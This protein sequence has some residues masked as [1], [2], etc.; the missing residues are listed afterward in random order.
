MIRRLPILFFIL[1]VSMTTIQVKGQDQPKNDQ[2]Q[3]RFNYK[4]LAQDP[5]SEYYNENINQPKDNVVAR[6]NYNFSRLKNPNTGKVPRNIREKELQYVRAER[7]KLQRSDDDQLIFKNGINIEAAAGDQA[8]AWDNRG[9]F[10]V[11]GRTR[12]L[13]IDIDNENILLAGGVSGGMWRSTDQGSTWV[14]ATTANQHPTVTDIVQDP[15]TGFHDTW[16]YSSGERIG[17]SQSARNGSGFLQGNGV[18]KSTDNGVSWSVLSATST[19][20]PQAFDTDFDLI[21]GVDINPTNGDLFVATMGGIYRSTDAGQSFTEVLPSDFDNFTDV[22]ITSTGV[23]YAALDNQNG[24]GGI[25]RT[26]DGAAGT[27]T[28]ITAP[29][30]PSSYSRTVIHTAPSDE[31]ILYVLSDGTPSS[32]V[33]HD[34]WKYTYSSGNGTGA[35]GTWENRS[36]NLPAIGGSVGDFNSQGGYDLYVRVHPT[37]PDMVFIGGTNIYRSDDGFATNSGE[38]IAGYSPQNNVSLYTNHHPDQHSLE[39]FP[40]DPSKAVSGHDGGVSITDDILADNGTIEPVTWTSLNNGYLTTQV[41]ALSIGPGDQLQAGFQDNSTWFTNNT[42]PTDSWVD[43][44]SGDGSYNAFNDDGTIR[45]VSSQL[46][47]VFRVSYADANSSISTAV[48]SISPADGL[49]VAPFELD[50]NNDQ[51]M[52]YAADEFLWRNDDLENATTVA[53]WTQLTNAEALS[54]VSIMG[55][56]TIPANIVYFGTVDGEVY[57]IEDANVGNPTA[58]DIYTGKGLPSGSNVSSID[59]NPYDADDVII[60]FSNYEVKSIFQTLDGG[61]TWT[62][63]SGNLEENENGSGSGPSVRW[64]DRVGNNDR[65]FAGTSTGL[66]ST[67][68][69]NGTSTVWTQENLDGI[70]N[71]VVE[72]LRTRNSDGLVVVGTHG[73]GLFSA[74]Y[75]V[76]QPDVTVN[77][78]ISD[79]TVEAGAPDDVIDVSNVFQSNTNPV[80]NVTVTVESN[81]NTT[82]V[83]TDVSG[84]SLTLSYLGSEFGKATITLRGTDENSESSFSQFIVT[85][86]P[87]PV[88]NYPYVLDFE[89]GVAEGWSTSGDMPWLLNS[90]ETGS[91]NTGPAVDN[92]LGNSTG[93]Y[94][95]SEASDP[96]VQG[97]EAILTS[98]EIDLTDV[99]SPK[100]QFYYHMFGSNMGSLKVQVND[101]TNSTNTEI[102]SVSGQQQA[103]Q[104]DDYLIADS[105]GLDLSDFIGS[106]IEVNFIATKGNEFRSDI[107]IDDI[108]FL[109]IQAP[110]NLSASAINTESFLL[111]WQDVAGSDNYEVSISSD[112]FASTLPG[113]DQLLVNTSSIEIT[114]LD[115]ETDYQVRVKTIIGNYTSNDSEISGGVT[116]RALPTASAAT[117][118]DFYSFTANWETYAGASSYKIE[119]SNDNFV[120]NISSFDMLDVNGT[121]VVVSGLASNTSYQYRISADLGSVLVGPSEA[122]DVTTLD[123]AVIAPTNLTLSESNGDIVLNW[124]DNSDLEDNYVVQRRA[125]AETA[126]SEYATVGADVVTYTDAN[127][128]ENVTYIYRVFGKNAADESSFSNQETIILSPQVPTAPNSLVLTENESS[129]S[130]S[131]VDNSLNEASFVIERKVSPETT[132]SEYETLGPNIVSFEDTDIAVGKTFSYRVSAK[133]SAGNSGF[134]NEESVTIASEVPVSPSSLTGTVS[135]TG[136]DLTWID[137]S[138]NET[139]IVVNR[140][141]STE[142][143]FVSLDTLGV[144]VTTFTDTSIESNKIYYYSV[145]ALNGLTNSDR[146]NEINVLTYPSVPVAG[147]ATQINGSSFVARWST[148]GESVEYLLDVTQ[149]DFETTLEEYTLR[150]VADTAITIEGLS[151][152]TEYKFRVKA[153]NT[154]GISDYSNVIV[155]NTLDVAPAAPSELTSILN[156]S[157]VLLTWTDNSANES[158]FEIE[159]AV[160]EGDF[161]ALTSV[162]SNT[163]GYTDDITE[164]TEDIS[165]RLYAKNGIGNSE[166]SNTTVVAYQVTSNVEEQLSKTFKVAPNPSTGYFKLSVG[167]KFKI[168]LVRVTDLS[169]R[170]VLEKMMTDEDR[171]TAKENEYNIDL[172]D[173]Y[174]GVYL[175]YIQSS[176]N[177]N[178]M[179]KVIKE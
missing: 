77:V 174:P 76:S 46:G 70:S 140:R 57:R 71:A 7:S 120:T 25:F 104:T 102:F 34:F 50:P 90:G 157:A 2:Q 44:F 179:K 55:V 163:T 89:D 65:Y 150:P 8:T 178:L 30:F 173:Q 62:D 92:T 12:A 56:S 128:S 137:N 58:T 159:R 22:H 134:S 10:N 20:I 153:K 3:T 48:A 88:T 116:T 138:D 85:V 82:L 177:Q 9:P 111:D 148:E 15:R 131:W 59:V 114:G 94:L 170:L 31:D 23:I 169:G 64:A 117:N 74:T 168:K 47:N 17:A 95:Y 105:E 110:Q 113:Y 115:P 36:T 108:E 155:V 29:G 123:D 109:E 73:N 84:S 144:D 145:Y 143:D 6:F 80:Q 112:L 33:Q 139:G 176:E 101:L 49:F 75:E 14:R 21:F 69:L 130:L 132:Y 93:K 81:S 165:Y 51:I 151:S 156:E 164:F 87:P 106:I 39:F 133:N 103:S 42:I 11:G 40:S 152:S 67:T 118:V 4:K 54:N 37:D 28:D 78:P 100:L 175:V 97:D 146:S 66:Y 43:V 161:Q 32:P 38:W 61:D 16:Y 125:G 79:F 52:Y 171:S 135:S 141:V 162:D 1:F 160:G 107:A 41:Y 124:T 35:G 154:S 13:A 24:E 63:V 91:P 121:S 68:N 45:Y 126:F 166:Y 83:S 86:L 147:D 5:N 19:N 122:I 127:V 129:I 26:T 18:Y 149:N 96:V 172:S 167:A 158:S 98:R 27:W 53:G 136:V 119:V 60:T 72:Q 142:S 99:T